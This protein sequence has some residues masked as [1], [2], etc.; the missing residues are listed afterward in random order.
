M[1]LIAALHWHPDA[2]FYQGL[3]GG[4][5]PCVTAEV[6]DSFRWNEPIKQVPIAVDQPM[7]VEEFRT[8]AGS[9][10]LRVLV[11]VIR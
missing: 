2:E 9:N 7:Y 4:L 11:E 10:D 3:Y 5:E 8:L 6:G 1:D